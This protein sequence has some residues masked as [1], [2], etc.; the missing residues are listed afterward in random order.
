MILLDT[1]VVSELMRPTP[2]PPVVAWFDLQPS[3]LLFLPA[4]AK[5]EIETGIVLLSDG[6]RRDALKLAA[7]AVFAEFEDRCLALDCVAAPTYAQVLAVSKQMG[8]PMSLE[9]A[10]IAAIALANG[11]KLATRNQQDFDFLRE[12]VLVD[13]WE[14]Q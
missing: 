7:D 12:L 5:A 1:N 14:S 9:E 2:A 6:K 10:Q 13:P 11:F 4:V 3:S 8:R